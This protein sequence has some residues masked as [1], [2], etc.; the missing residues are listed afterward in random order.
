MLRKTDYF[1]MRIIWIIQEERS[2]VLIIIEPSSTK[3]VEA[4]PTATANQTVLN[5]LISHILVD[6]V[7]RI[8]DQ[9]IQEVKIAYNFVGE[10]PVNEPVGTDS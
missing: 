7:K 6:K 1:S 8:D 9:K 3:Y 5:C 10:I 4:L 2:I